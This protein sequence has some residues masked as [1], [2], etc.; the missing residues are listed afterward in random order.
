MFILVPGGCKPFGKLGAKMV[1]YDFP[2]IRRVLVSYSRPN[3]FV[4][5]RG[6]SE[7]GG[8]SVL[9][10]LRGLTRSFAWD[11]NALCDVLNIAEQFQSVSFSFSF[12]LSSPEPG[13][14]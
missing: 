13:C 12:S 5:F 7:N 6:K 14:E 8:D 1:R 11:E 4:R 3:R 10:P 2:S 9:D